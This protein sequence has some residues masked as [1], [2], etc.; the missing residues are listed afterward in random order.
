MEKPF[1]AY[2]GSNP[3]TFVSYAHDD[4]A[5]VYPE[6]T[7]LKA[8][9]FNIWYDEGISPGATWRD[10]V[11]LALTQ[12]KVFLYFITP[13]SAASSNCR[14]EVNFCLS[15]ERK[16]LCVYLSKTELPVGLELS[17]SDMQAIDRSQ[18][19]DHDYQQKLS[20]ALTSL[21][22]DTADLTVIPSRQPGV[23]RKS[24]A[25]L[26]LVNRSNDPDNEYLCEGISEELT[27]GLASVEGLKVASQLSSFSLKNQNIDVG[28]IGEKLNVDHVLSGSVQKADGRVRISVLLSQVK[29]GSSL[30]SNRFDRELQDIFELQEDVARQ[31]VDALKV[32]LGANEHALLVDVGTQSVQ[33]FEAFLVGLNKAR[34]GTSRSLQQAVV[35]FQQ[36][37][38]LDPEFARIYWWLY[39]CYWRLIGVG[40]PRQEM[41]LKAEDALDRAKAAGFTPPVPWIKA[42]RDLFPEVRPDQRVLAEEACMKIRQPDQEWQSFEYVQLGDCLIAAGLNHGAYD[43][44]HAYLD[45]AHHDLS[46]T[47]ILQRYRY[48]L[49]QVG[50]F[51]RA[52]DL[53]TED[54][55]RNP[56]AVAERSAL[57]SRTGQY[58][59]AEQD[60]A[61]LHE[62]YRRQ[63]IYDFYYLYWRRELD[64]TKTS[65]LD[66]HEPQ[67]RCMGCFLLG[68]I[69]GGINHLEEEIRRGT[70]PAVF[71]SNIGAMLPRSILREVEQ[72]PRFQAILEQFG[73]DA[74]WLD[75]LMMMASNLADITGIRVQVDDD[76]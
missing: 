39:F 60:L 74:A 61:C 64:A 55:A 1:P 68:D 35:H 27:S 20:D 46:A 40:L 15:R 70:H 44:Y 58:E 5:L 63:N 8:Q 33:A 26:P 42:R 73:I 7:R 18:Y 32:E 67:Y 11:A 22:P 41:E 69:D 65:W 50:R 57:Y 21:L 54:I 34:R 10:E 30:W 25:I 66:N 59:K 62:S 36:A 16:I 75:E 13:G 28:L 6:I 43:Y 12:C 17:L 45:R 49:Q 71:R 51:D 3:Y 56:W 31:V 24:I 37:A 53:C 76:Y 47:W 2:Q 19:S 4:A 9:G 52:I 23:C 72:H 14:K 48:L 29:D 38:Q